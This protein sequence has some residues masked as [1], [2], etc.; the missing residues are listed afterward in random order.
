MARSWSTFCLNAALDIA[1]C[2]NP[3]EGSSYQE[4]LLEMTGQRTVPNVFVNKKHVGGCD[5][6]MQVINKSVTWFLL[7]CLEKWVTF[8]IEVTQYTWYLKI[9]LYNILFY[10]H[11][12]CHWVVVCFHLFENM[13]MHQL[14]IILN[15][16]FTAAGISCSHCTAAGWACRFKKVHYRCIDFNK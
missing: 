5:N 14:I 10:C 4:M 9:I 11:V 8:H 16:L 3:E 2:V 13:L 7:W 15:E 12:V 1:L 6:T